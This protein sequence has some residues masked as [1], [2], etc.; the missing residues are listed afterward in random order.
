MLLKRLNLRIPAVGT[1]F[2]KTAVYT[3]YL[4]IFKSIVNFEIEHLIREHMK[5]YSLFKH[6]FPKHVFSRNIGT[7]FH[8]LVN[9]AILF[10][11][12]RSSLHITLS[13]VIITDKQ[14]E[15]FE[16]RN[17]SSNIQKPHAIIFARNFL[18]LFS[19][20]VPLFETK[21]G[22]GAGIRQ[23]SRLKNYVRLPMSINI[24]ARIKWKIMLPGGHCPI[25]D[26][27]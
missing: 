21:A 23:R 25:Y 16:L 2:G 19:M 22:F 12:L 20:W 3:I 13:K 10:Q 27:C 1:S 7:S 14:T 18:A 26:P 4:D 6:T 9:H 24:L 8:F 11:N 15:S 5:N 17:I